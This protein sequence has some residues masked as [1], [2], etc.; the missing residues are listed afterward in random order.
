M[1]LK[2]PGALYP[3]DLLMFKGVMIDLSRQIIRSPKLR[4]RSCWYQD[5]HKDL[6]HSKQP[7]P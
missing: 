6:L 5:L 2:I 1:T 3:W 4:E 7:E